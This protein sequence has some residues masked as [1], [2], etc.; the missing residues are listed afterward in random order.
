MPRSFYTSPRKNGKSFLCSAIL[1]YML[2]ADKEA[3][4][5]VWGGPLG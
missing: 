3:A 2:V 4:P 5:E 1:L